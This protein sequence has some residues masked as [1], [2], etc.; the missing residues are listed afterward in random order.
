MLLSKTW[1]HF[2]F[3]DRTWIVFIMYV[4]FFSISEDVFILY[5]VFFPI[6]EA[7]YEAEIIGSIFYV[8]HHD[9]TCIIKYI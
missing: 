1:E 4:Y 9:Y 3:P 2:F 5:I 6:P 7:F 8:S